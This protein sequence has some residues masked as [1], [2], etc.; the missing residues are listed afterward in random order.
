MPGQAARTAECDNTTQSLQDVSTDLSCCS[1]FLFALTLDSD[2]ASKL[3][4]VHL[5]EE[6]WVPGGVV[7]KRRR[8][9]RENRWL[10]R[11]LARLSKFLQGEGALR[12]R[13][14]ILTANCYAYCFGDAFESETD[15]RTAGL[16]A[17][18]R[19]QVHLHL[20]Q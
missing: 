13:N 1:R 17:E 3:E 14:T 8:A 15:S 12:I 18:L 16:V 6:G 7:D 9:F 4:V 10:R 5:R 19:S 11:T 2:L 20:A